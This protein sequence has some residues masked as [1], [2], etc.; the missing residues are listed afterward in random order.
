MNL[1][2]LLYCDSET[3]SNLYYATQFLVP[4]PVLFIEHRGKKYLLLNDLEIDRG[5]KEATV[6]VVLSLSELEQAFRKKNNRAGT[7]PELIALCLKKLK[8][9]NLLLPRTFPAFYADHLKRLGF[10]MTFGEDPF[11]QERILKTA[12]EKKFITQTQSINGKAIE[13]AYQVLRDSRIKGKYIYY[14]NQKLTS[15]KLKEVMEVFLLRNG[16]LGQNTI[17]ASGNQAVDPHCRGTGPLLAN[18][19]III[20]TFPRNLKNRYH[21]DMTRTTIKGRG[22][23]AMR[24][25]WQ[26]VYQGQT[27]GIK[28]AK[29]DINGKSIHEGIQKQFED[30]GYQ[31]GVIKGRMQGFFHG[32]GHGIGLDIHEA[33]RVAKR[34][35]ILKVR[36]VVTIE[37]GLYYHGIG[38]VRIED[39]V[40]I[41]QNRAEVLG[42]SC[43]KIMEIP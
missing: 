36:D 22:T 39:I 19:L 27:W 15:E 29:A 17:I 32:T 43:P 24:K 37:P 7:M 28:Q 20:D 21:G 25:Q 6:D 16:C 42:G 40:Y 14:Q 30:Q 10:K 13:Q 35:H 26:A 5:K 38:G 33:P 4:D 18:S 11:Y 3:D 2:K 34:D 31:T 41:H 1:T 12:E 8:C 23:D 9:K